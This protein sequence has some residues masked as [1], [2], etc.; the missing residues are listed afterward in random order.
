MRPGPRTRRRHAGWPRPPRPRGPGRAA[1]ARARA[2]AR[3]RG[4]WPPDRPPPP[5]RPRPAAGAARP[6]RTRP[7]PPPDRRRGR[8]RVDARRASSSASGQAPWSV[9]R[10]ARYTRHEPRYG[11]RSGWASHQ[12]ERAAVHSCARPRSKISPA[13]LD[14][15]AVDDPHHHRR[16]LA[17]RHRH[18]R[19]VEHGDAVG[20]LA[21]PDQGFAQPQSGDRRQVRVRVQAGDAGGLGEC[22]VGGLELAGLFV[23]EGRG[24]EQVAV[25]D[26][27]PCPPRRR[28]A[29]PGPAS[30]RRGPARCGTA[31]RTRA[32]RHSERRDRRHR[33]EAPPGAP[34]SAGRPTRHRVRSGRHRSRSARGRPVRAV[35]LDP[36][37]QAGRRHRTTTRP[38]R[39]RD[40][41]RGRPRRSLA[42]ASLVA[43]SGT[44]RRSWEPPTPGARQTADYHGRRISDARG[45]ER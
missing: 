36:P 15:G 13:R 20:D 18:H 42:Q 11:T 28:A 2:A 44:L 14:G 40:R 32:R 16:H 1:A 24:N 23:L 10:S 9:I 39:P 37:R 43:M 29:P 6:G 21:E 38:R 17:G 7:D 41:A 5:P 30:P 12:P 45:R 34:G 33:L 35:P 4:C 22:R 3:V 8:L 27:S 26:A 25:D 19:L 31:G